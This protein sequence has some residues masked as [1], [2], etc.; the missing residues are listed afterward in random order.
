ME[1]H[2]NHQLQTND[3]QNENEEKNM[4]SLSAADDQNEIGSEGF[5]QS[6]LQRNDSL[7]ASDRDEDDDD[8]DDRETDDDDD[9]DFDSEEDDDDDDDFNDDS[10]DDDQE[11]DD[12]NEGIA[13]SDWGTVDPQEHPGPRSGMDPSAPGSAV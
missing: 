8:D 5:V 3:W 9:D 10:D 13:D 4:Q 1:N 6:D 2:T 7:S 11:D 12:D